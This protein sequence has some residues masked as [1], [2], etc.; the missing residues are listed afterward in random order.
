MAELEEDATEG[1]LADYLAAELSGDRGNWNL[2]I[3]EYRC[4]KCGHWHEL[5]HDDLPDYTNLILGWHKKAREGADYFSQFVFE[6]LA[7]IAHLKNNLF[8]AETN[9]RQAIQALKRDQM[10][11]SR[12][13]N[14]VKAD[15]RLRHILQRLKEELKE[16]PLHNS[17]LD[18]DYPEID[19]WWNCS[20]CQP[21]RDQTPRTGV[22]RSVG[23]WDNIVEFWYGVRN[24]LFHGGKSPNIKRDLF[25]VE[26]AYETLKVFMDAELNDLGREAGFGGPAP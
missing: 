2:G 4:P 17:S 16:R 21:G 22:I 19:R 1:E 13:R 14:A 25:I 10:R 24:N 8:F 3:V 7:F 12:Y 15:T 20:A 9:D 26:H 11:R 6:Y 18:L 23:D 5:Q